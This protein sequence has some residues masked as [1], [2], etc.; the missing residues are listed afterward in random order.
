MTQGEQSPA[1]SARA[2][3]GDRGKVIDEAIREANEAHQRAL[4]ELH[5]HCQKTEFEAQLELSRATH[6]AYLEQ[7]RAEGDAYWR[8]IEAVRGLPPEEQG[9]AFEKIQAYQREVWERRLETEKACAEAT[10]RFDEAMRGLREESLERAN[11]VHD[12]HVRR[13]KALWADVDP[14]RLKPEDLH[15]L[16]HLVAAAAHCSPKQRA[17]AG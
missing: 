7:R 9:A 2:A 16:A 10:R 3:K 15:A 14:A 8:M 5:S 6:E 4:A 1:R 13:V 17:N 11:A 12:D